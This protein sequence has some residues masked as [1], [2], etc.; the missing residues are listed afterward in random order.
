MTE[1]QE[2][3]TR[4]LEWAT[5]ADASPSPHSLKGVVPALGVAAAGLVLG[6]LLPGGGKRNGGLVSS[7]VGNAFS[8]AT[9]VPI[10]KVV[11]PI[12]LKKR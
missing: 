12:L 11:L 3:K 5:K 7:I 9:I 6:R 8:L 4:L 2:A 1:V 10:A